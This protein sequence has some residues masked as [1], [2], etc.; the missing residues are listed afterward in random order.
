MAVDELDGDATIPRPGF[1]ARRN[2][3]PLAVAGSLCIAA[4]AGFVKLSGVDG[5]TAAVLRCALALLVLLPLTLLE[6]R[7]H[8]PRPRR[9]RLLDLAA[10]G[11][12]GVDFVLWG[13]AI[14]RV[15]ASITSVLLNMQVVVFPLL[16]L[17]FTRTRPSGRYWRTV[18][19]LLLGVAL[20]GGALGSSEPGSDPVRG[21]V[22]GTLAGCAFAGYLFLTR[23]A[24]G[25]TPHAVHPVCTSTTGA[26]LTS[27]VLGAAWTGVEPAPG[28]GPLG[29]L[30]GAALLGQVLAW[31]LIGQALP[32]LSA[33]TGSAL[34]VLQP[35]AAIVFGLFLDERPTWTQWAGSALVLLGV[36]YASRAEREATPTG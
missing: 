18:P 3:V 21:A 7:R 19:V 9:L 28:W 22:Y 11:L 26:L 6:R 16:A 5:G 4:P 25:R 32:R 27:A 29:W 31:M 8:G 34:L 10:G 13:E 30:A 36:W 20:A 2:P 1:L 33:A 15:G 12:L 14:S 17:V 23:L 24:G 35:V